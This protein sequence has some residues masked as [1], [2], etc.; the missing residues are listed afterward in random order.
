M[1]L[2]KETFDVDLWPNY[3]GQYKSTNTNPQEEF[4]I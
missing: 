2:T 3:L 1:A 4:P